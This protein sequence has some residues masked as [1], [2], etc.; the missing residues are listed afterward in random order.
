M[1]QPCELLYTCYL[2]YVPPTCSCIHFVIHPPVAILVFPSSPIPF[3]VVFTAAPYSRTVLAMCSVEQCRG[4]VFVFSNK[5]KKCCNTVALLQLSTTVFCSSI[6]HFTEQLLSI[7][8]LTDCNHWQ[9][10]QTTSLE[11]LHK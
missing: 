3:C 11:F 1:W 7:L 6:R 2:L 10:F 8:T 9:D 4:I 5:T